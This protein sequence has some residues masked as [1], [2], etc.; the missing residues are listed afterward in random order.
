LPLLDLVADELNVKRVVFAESAERFGRWHAKPNYRVLGPKLGP[1]VKGLAD[2]LA[3]DD[4]TAAGALSRGER[5]TV[6]GV[7][8]GP[9]D[10]DLSQEVVEGW[11]VASDAGVTVAL[12]LALT[13][14]LR[15]EGIA[16]E[17]VRVVQDARKAAGLAVADRIVLGL[18]AEAAVADALAAHSDY[19][20]QETLAVSVED[21]EFDGWHEDAV[22]E[23]LALRLSL[24]KA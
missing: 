24:R 7:E 6:A 22:V 18:R 21:G 12:D 19:L 14:E 13:P 15:S 2:A 16:R 1:S 8:L 4:G 20:A 11:G 23:G 3:S 9:D 5:V 10:V 17:V